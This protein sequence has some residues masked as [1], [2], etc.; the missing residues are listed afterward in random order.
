[1][2]GGVIESPLKGYRRTGKRGREWVEGGWLGE[3]KERR[4][5]ARASLIQAH[6]RNVRIGKKKTKQNKNIG[7]SNTQR[8]VMI[9]TYVSY[10]C[11][12]YYIVQA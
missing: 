12:S 7:E 1:M 5:W 11:I 10:F 3:T 9:K 6:R 8:N 2:G 4:P